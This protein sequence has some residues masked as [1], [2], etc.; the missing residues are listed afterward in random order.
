M[1]PN[2]AGVVIGLDTI[3]DSANTVSF[4]QARLHCEP[5]LP[6]DAVEFS[7]ASPYIDYHSSVGEIVMMVND[8]GDCVL[9]IGQP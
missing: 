8:Y 4:D 6:S 7:S 1:T 2:A 3:S 9:N 5:W